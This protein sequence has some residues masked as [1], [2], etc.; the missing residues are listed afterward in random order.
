M[1]HI[2]SLKQF[3]I[4]TSLFSSVLLGTQFARANSSIFQNPVSHNPLGVSDSRSVA[5]FQRKDWEITKEGTD[6]KCL[7]SKTKYTYHR[8]KTTKL[9]WSK[10]ATGHGTPPSAWKVYDETSK[11]LEWKADA[12]R[13]GDFIQDKHKGPTGLSIPFSELSCG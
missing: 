4:V 5:L 8:H 2:V 13:Y 10:D 12:D 7:H 1:M 9:W 6:R 11:S 3:F